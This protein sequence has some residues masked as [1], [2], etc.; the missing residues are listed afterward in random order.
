MR[1]LIP[2]LLLCSFFAC[3]EPEP[4]VEEVTMEEEEV[5]TTAALDVAPELLN[6]DLVARLDGFFEHLKEDYEAVDEGSCRIVDQ[7]TITCSAFFKKRTDIEGTG[8]YPRLNVSLYVFPDAE[9]ADNKIVEFLSEFDSSSEQIVIGENIEAIK[10]T[11][12]HILLCGNEAVVMQYPC[13]HIENDWQ[14]LLDDLIEH[15]TEPGNDTNYWLG[16]MYECGINL[17]W[18]QRF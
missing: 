5:D 11:P 13:E 10:T 18:E 17:T 14:V 9:T 16:S 7:S 6:D 1:Y 4:E 15:F 8:V 2:T 3:S 12:M